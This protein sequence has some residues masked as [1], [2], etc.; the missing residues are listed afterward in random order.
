[1]LTQTTGTRGKVRSIWRISFTFVLA[2]SCLL[3]NSA[4]ASDEASTR[5]VSEIDKLSPS[6]YLTLAG[7]FGSIGLVGLVGLTFEVGPVQFGVRASTTS[8][9]SILGPPSLQ[10]DEDVSLL[11]GIFRREGATRF[12]L[13]SGVGVATITRRHPKPDQ[14]DTWSIQYDGTDEDVVSIPFQAGVIWDAHF[15]GIGLAVFANVNSKVKDGGIV[16]TLHAGKM[17]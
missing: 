8:A 6:V 14:D 7:G 10:L 3:A 1:M 13:S 16:L 5:P 12:Y 11:A 17:R 9:L 2:G 15:V 4:L